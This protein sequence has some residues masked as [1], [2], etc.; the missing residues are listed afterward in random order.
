MLL[1]TV[2]L[3]PIQYIFF[4]CLLVC[5]YRCSLCLF[6]DSGRTC[7]SLWHTSTLLS[8]APP[9]FCLTLLGFM[10]KWSQTVGLLPTR[11]KATVSHPVSQ[12]VVQQIWPTRHSPALRHLQCLPLWLPDRA[13]TTAWCAELQWSSSVYLLLTII[14]LLMPVGQWSEL[15]DVCS[16]LYNVDTS[17]LRV[18]HYCPSII[19]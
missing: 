14:F 13:D 19:L 3:I 9:A 7:E 1:W 16:C 15:C 18:I 2:V 10:F 4:E 6:I 12:R 5:T 17:L 8:F 11:P